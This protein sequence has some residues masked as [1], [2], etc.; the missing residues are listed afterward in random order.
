MKQQGTRILLDVQ[1]NAPLVIM[2]RHST[3]VDM[4]IADLGHLELQNEFVVFEL[5]KKEDEGK[6][7]ED[8]AKKYITFDVMELTLQSVQLSRFVD[9]SNTPPS[10]ACNMS[11]VRL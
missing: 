5:E 3:S 6:E 1:I 4:L 2:P 8:S 11:H 7:N 10:S 9:N